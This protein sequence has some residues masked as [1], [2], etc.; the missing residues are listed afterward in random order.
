[1]YAM[2]EGAANFN[3]SLDRWNVSSVTNMHSMFREANSF[4]QNISNWDVSSNPLHTDFAS[5]CPIDGT[6]KEPNWP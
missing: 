6:S 4:D 2:F 1:M 5:G 3:Q